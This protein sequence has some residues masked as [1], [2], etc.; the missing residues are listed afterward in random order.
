M[1]NVGIINLGQNLRP[2]AHAR[3]GG[4]TFLALVF[5]IGGLI[6]TVAITFAILSVSFAGQTYA[7]QSATVAEAAATAGV[8]DAQV[9]LIRNSSFSSGGY[10]V[11]SGAANA[12][13]VVTQ[14][15][16]ATGFVTVV[17]ASTV[18]LNIRKIQAV[19]YEN[20]STSQISLA[21]WQFT[22]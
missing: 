12:S 8:E 21:S 15:S 2:C 10:T 5:L 4:Q 14:N 7:F 22:Q 18:A 20:A 9:Q 6:A 3:R 17:S 16:P 13:V 11:N 19:F 1:L